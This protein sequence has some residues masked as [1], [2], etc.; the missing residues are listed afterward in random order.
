[1]G[2]RTA[3]RLGAA[4]L[5]LACAGS[6][7]AEEPSANDKN[8]A[9]SLFDEAR[10]LMDGGHY[11]EACPRFE[12]SERLDPGGGTLLNLALCYEKLGK[13]ALAY[14]TYNDAISLAI[15][16]HRRE[17]E[18]FARDRVAA[19]APRLPH[20]KLEVT[21]AP[22]LEVEIDGA[23]VPRSAWGTATAVD[24][25][26]HVVAA[27]APGYAPLQ[28][29]VTSA[30][31]DSRTIAVALAPEPPAV[32]AQAP[33]PSPPRVPMPLAAR[34]ER[35][36]TAA[37]YVAGGLSLSSLV[38]S[39]VTGGLAWSAHESAASKCS[40]ATGFCADPGGVSDASHARTLAWVSTAT[41][42]GGVAA[43]V[44]AF[45]L[46]RGPRVA[47]GAIPGGATVSAVVSWR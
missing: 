16:E 3:R 1:M 44:V 37:F 43:G 36:R 41:L 47:V 6:A 10:R 39:A 30:E 35:R 2:C 17:R 46:P 45:A 25:G 40:A 38:A 26:T 29:Q 4:C 42:L 31:G 15:E 33:A 18:S 8:I 20:L 5:L 22:G 21:D 13:L 11:A 7:H 19:I 12:G 34:T 9:Q 14:R 32:V 27:S 23:P 28:A 24:P